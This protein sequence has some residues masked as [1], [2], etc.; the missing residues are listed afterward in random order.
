MYVNSYAGKRGGRSIFAGVVNPLFL[1]A[2][3]EADIVGNETFAAYFDLDIA[4]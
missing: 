1:A 2:G 3:V 4:C